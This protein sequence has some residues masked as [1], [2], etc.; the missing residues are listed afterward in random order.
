[1]SVDEMVTAL[2]LGFMWSIFFWVIFYV[3]REDV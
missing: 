1:M 2:V 3:G